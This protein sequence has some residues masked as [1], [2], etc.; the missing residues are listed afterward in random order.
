MNDKEFNVGDLILGF[1]NHYYI[2]ISNSSDTINCIIYCR[3]GYTA[4]RTFSNDR[5]TYL[6]YGYT[7]YPI[8]PHINIG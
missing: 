1:R 3:D 4:K 8:K 2:V 6:Q 5:R 7:I